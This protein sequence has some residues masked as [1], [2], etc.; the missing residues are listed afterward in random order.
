[1]VLGAIGINIGPDCSRPIDPDMFLGF[2]LNLEVTMSLGFNE[3]QLDLCNAKRS[4]TIVHQHGLKFQP[5][6]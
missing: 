3:P 6:L 5:I 4:M 2:R 1:M